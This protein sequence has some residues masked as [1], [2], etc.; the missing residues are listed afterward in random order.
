[1]REKRR[2]LGYVLT[3]AF[4]AAVFFAAI[5]Q[6]TQDRQ[7]QAKLQL[8][9]ILRKTAAACYAAQGFYPPSVDYMCAHYG[10]TYDT[11]QFQVEYERFASNLMPD[12]TVIEK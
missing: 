5:G 4:I 9:D 11:E 1:M 3:A 7:E 12:I 8:E 6:L 10:L 2:I